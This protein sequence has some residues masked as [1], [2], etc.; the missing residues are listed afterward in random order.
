MILLQTFTIRQ[1]IFANSQ[2]FT[3]TKPFLAPGTPEFQA[4]FDRLTSLKRTEG[5]TRFTDRSSLY[6]IHGE[7]KFT[8]TFLDQITIG[9][10]A[11]LYDPVSEG[12][13][14]YDTAG[15]DITN[16]EYGIYGGIEKSFSDKRWKFQGT[17]RLDKNENYD[18][19]F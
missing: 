3:T 6:H 18:Y 19:L 2:T 1:K 8:P 17:F 16:F 5:G 10:N 12:T 4:E 7:Y 13:I 15:V 14:F 11:R 9:A